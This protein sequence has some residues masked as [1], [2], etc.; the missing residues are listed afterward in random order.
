MGYQ[1]DEPNL[2]TNL[3]AGM[4]CGRA[5][6]HGLP[7]PTTPDVVIC[8][9]IRILSSCMSVGNG[10]VVEIK[11]SRTWMGV[12]HYQKEFSTIDAKTDDSRPFRHPFLVSTVDATHHYVSINSREVD[13]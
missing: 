11:I 7:P 3:F 4:C 9:C 13:H 12:I 8:C 2:K 10:G 1:M 6:T 5:W